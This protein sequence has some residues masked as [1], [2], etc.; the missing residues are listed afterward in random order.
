MNMPDAL[1]AVFAVFAIASTAFAFLAKRLVYSVLSLALAAAFSS[2]IFLLLGQEF[3][4][5]MQLLFFT[6]CLSACLIVATAAEEKIKRTISIGRF[7]A[8]AA[9]L[10]AP[11]LYVAVIAPSAAASLQNSDFLQYAAGAFSSYYVFLY[12]IVTLLFA[13]AVGSAIVIKKIQG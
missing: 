2:L 13:G 6:C 11:L 12:M 8:A 9:I 7:S 1:L 3:V 5:L 10:S 4:A